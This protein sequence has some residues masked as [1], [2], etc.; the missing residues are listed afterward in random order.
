MAIKSRDEILAAVRASVADDTSDAALEL[1]ADI[2]DTLDDLTSNDYKT[3]YENNDRM[4]R[5]KYRDRFM[6]GGDKDPDDDDDDDDGNVPP[7]TYSFDN[8]FKE[9]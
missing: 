7:K 4:W 9:E 5:Q 6:S 3:M 8:L 1:M 2:S